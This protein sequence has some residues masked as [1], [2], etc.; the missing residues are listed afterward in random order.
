MKSLSSKYAVEISEEASKRGRW[1]T[2]LLFK[3][4]ETMAEKL[5]E[6]VRRYWNTAWTVQTI[7]AKFRHITILDNSRLG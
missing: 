4:L 1:T 7:A 6:D 2:S 3:A 5:G